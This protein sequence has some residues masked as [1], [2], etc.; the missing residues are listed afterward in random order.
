[1]FR[2]SLPG[3]SPV[4]GQQ[5]GIVTRSAMRRRLALRE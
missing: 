4:L 5:H 1:M 3:A 2:I